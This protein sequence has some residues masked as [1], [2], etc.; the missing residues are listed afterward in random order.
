MR[1]RRFPGVRAAGPAGQADFLELH[2]RRIAAPYEGLFA[3]FFLCDDFRQ[4]AFAGIELRGDPIAVGGCS[5]AAFFRF[6]APERTQRDLD[7]L[8]FVEECL[9]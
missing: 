7:A 8:Q 9:V 1:E 3:L 5:P 4:H 6:L 2:G